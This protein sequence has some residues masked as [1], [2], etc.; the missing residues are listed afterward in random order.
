M[1][2]NTYRGVTY[3]QRPSIGVAA[4]STL[5]QMNLVAP[6][7]ISQIMPTLI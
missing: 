4:N 3:A 5:A 7:N 2:L 1:L 6:E